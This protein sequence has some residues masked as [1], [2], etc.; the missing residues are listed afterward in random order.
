L[1][2]MKNQAPIHNQLV[3]I[4]RIPAMRPGTNA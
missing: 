3:K 4:E 2:W 1:K